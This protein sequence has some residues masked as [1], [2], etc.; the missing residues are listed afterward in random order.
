MQGLYMSVPP[1]PGGTQRHL[2]RV[3][4]QRANPFLIRAYNRVAREHAGLELMPEPVD[5]AK[6]T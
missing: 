2:L 4:G 5:N 3:R 6:V 1:G